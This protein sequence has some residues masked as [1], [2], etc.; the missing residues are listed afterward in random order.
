[1]TQGN[2]HLLVLFPDCTSQSPLYSR[3]AW[4]FATTTFANPPKSRSR[5]HIQNW[6]NWGFASQSSLIGSELASLVRS[7]CPEL[8][9][10][11]LTITQQPWTK[12][13][14]TGMPDAL[15]EL[16]P[17]TSKLD[18]VMVDFMNNRSK[19]KRVELDLGQTTKGN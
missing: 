17:T 2:E 15:E 12:P 8:R 4:F 19:L 9:R 16:I 1:M 3:S 11:T 5:R 10:L 13:M 14:I 7:S 18:Y 6:I